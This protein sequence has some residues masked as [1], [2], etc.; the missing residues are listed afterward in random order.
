VYA[1][2]VPTRIRFVDASRQIEGSAVTEDWGIPSWTTIWAV[3][4]EVYFTMIAAWL[5][6]GL[7]VEYVVAFEL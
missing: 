2:V 4:L 3:P 6:V 7:T 5:V 1:V